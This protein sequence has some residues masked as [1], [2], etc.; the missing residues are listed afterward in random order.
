MASVLGAPALLVG[1]P[2]TRRAHLTAAVVLAALVV[3]ASA[4]SAQA[5]TQGPLWGCRAS[6]VY[7][8]LAG[9]NR[10][11][12]VVANGNP[13]TSKGASPDRAQCAIQEAGAGNLLTPLGIPQES[14]GAQSAYARTAITPEIGRAIDQSVGAAAGVEKLNLGSGTQ[15]ITVDAATSQASATCSG[16]A[17]K[18]TGSSNVVNLNIAGNNISVDTVLQMVA[19]G[20]TG[21]PLSALIKIKFNE[22][23]KDG[24]Q[25]IQR[26]AHITII[27]AAGGAPLLDVVIAE[28][29]VNANGLVCDEAAN[30]VG[31]GGVG[32]TISARPCPAG[33]QYDVGRNLCIITATSQN[34]EII[35]GRP[36]Q[37][38][39]GGTV[40]ALSIARKKF[41]SV[42]LQGG[43]PQYAVIGTN[44]N[45]HITGTNHR[46]RIL[47]L[48]GNDAVD[49]GRGSDCIDGG[50][51]SDN[52][53]GGLGN[54]HLI[55][56]TGN[57]HLNGGPGNDLEEAG[58][59]NDTINAAFG[60]DRAMGGA[61]RDFI[62]IA[63]AGPPA[64]AN[65][66]SGFDKV[67]LNKNET[68]R[69]T[70][71]EVMYIFKD[72]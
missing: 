52:L 8:S 3:L 65:C 15:S 43:G 62:N 63:T 41:H 33:S 14:I 68:K 1:T 2:R 67:R 66:G 51:G 55:G 9:N 17:P 28:S 49:G 25:L 37:G 26:A 18:F 61:G 70:A 71:C 58:S 11:E 42:C 64:K 57:D 4:G 39:S 27:P 56:A 36:Y 6:A 50:T 46:D 13:N 48:G 21:S 22:Q 60:R 20:I 44:K 12:P 69:V 16:G 7:A 45:D 31:S 32:G 34:P 47:A 35:V 19:D 72:R 5:L 30:T 23:I 29:K 10:V 54:D 59:G 24:S 40:V 38:P 53:S